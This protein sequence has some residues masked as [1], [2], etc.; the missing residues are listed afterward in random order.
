MGMNFQTNTVAR[1]GAGGGVIHIAATQDLRLEAGGG[2]NVCP[3]FHILYNYTP[4]CSP[5]VLPF[6]P[7]CF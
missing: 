5:C 3:V 4:S 7:L 6:A 2:T 1:A